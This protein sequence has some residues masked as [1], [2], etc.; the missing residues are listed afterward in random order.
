[1]HKRHK[2]YYVNRNNEKVTGV[3]IRVNK[4][5]KTIFALDI[6]KGLAHGFRREYTNDGRI[7]RKCIMKKGGQKSCREYL[8]KDVR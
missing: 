2:F 4:Y 8:K 3:A 1:M 5:G 7:I 6:N